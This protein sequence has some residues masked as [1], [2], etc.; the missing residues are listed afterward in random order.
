MQRRR[1]ELAGSCLRVNL[2]MQWWTSHW[3]LQPAGP[4]APAAAAAQGSRSWALRRAA[5]AEYMLARTKPTLQVHGTSTQQRWSHSATHP[6]RSARAPPRLSANKQGVGLTATQH[7]DSTHKRQ[8][9]I[10][11]NCVCLLNLN[12]LTLVA[13]VRKCPVGDQLGAHKVGMCTRIRRGR[14]K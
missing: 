12:V 13:A 14:Y 10:H 4:L 6:L 3:A 5:G 2:Q 8:A 7:C 1:E 9:S 11:C